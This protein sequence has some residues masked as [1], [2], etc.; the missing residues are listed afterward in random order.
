MGIR[1]ADQWVLYFF[2][3]CLCGWVWESC[4]VSLRQRRWVNRGFLHGPLLPIYGTGAVLILLATIRVQDSPALIFLLGMTAATVLEYF[5]GAAMEGLLKV[6]Y[7]DYTSQ[8]FNLKGYICLTSTLAWG[9]FSVVLVK[10][11]HPPVEK[12]LGGVPA[13]WAGPAALALTAAAGVDAVRS[14]R[15]ALDL[16]EILT[17]LTEE[18]EDLRRLAKRVE[19]ASAFAEDD[20]RRFRERTEVEK[21]LLSDRMAAERQ[22]QREAH[23]ERVLKWQELLEENLRR[24]TSAKLRAMD[25]VAE[26]LEAYRRTLEETR[27]LAGE[28]LEEHRREV[29]EGLEKLRSEE[30]RVRARTA[31]TYRR[32]L[33]ILRGNP[34][35]SAKKY[36]EA[37]ENLRR[38]GGMHRD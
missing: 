4:Y 6:R 21:I 19:V 20:L 30:A 16:R 23:A 8:R 24:R 18:N 1:T 13:A 12:L 25:A 37:L 34:S 28:A 11:I 15:A 26:A 3:Y 35:A 14:F 7:W 29:A 5:T 17:R 32:S 27:E 31:E 22:R 2:F 38:L 36:A 33:R 10:G 9:V